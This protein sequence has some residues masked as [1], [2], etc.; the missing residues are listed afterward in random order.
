MKTQKFS[1]NSK[2]DLK[3][4]VEKFQSENPSAVFAEG[5]LAKAETVAMRLDN[6]AEGGR[7]E[8]ELSYDENPI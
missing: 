7:I 3:S 6:Q 1:I 2:A 5:S 4:K 8:I